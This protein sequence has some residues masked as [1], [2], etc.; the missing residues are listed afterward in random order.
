MTISAKLIKQCKK[1]QRKAQFELY[2]ICYQPMMNICSRYYQN[3]D[4]AAGALNMA[5]FKVLTKL[6]RYS[7]KVPFIA[8]IKRITINTVIDEFRKNKKVKEVTDYYES[9]DALFENMNV[10][11]NTAALKL[12]AKHLEQFINNL[13]EMCAKIFNLY[14]I[15]GYSHAEV[16]DMFGISAGTSK[17]YV[18]D[19]RKRLKQMIENA[20]KK[21]LVNS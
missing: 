9:T 10:D 16:G 6:D 21:D 17:W 13:P 2:Q 19:A 18:S 14:A 1:G 11:F 4:E 20:M 7:P 5:Y 8:W 12:D 3:S 15:D